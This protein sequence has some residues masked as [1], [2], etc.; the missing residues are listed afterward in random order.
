M[1]MKIRIEILSGWPVPEIPDP[2]LV[3]SGLPR[4]AQCLLI[5]FGQSLPFNAIQG[6]PERHGDSFRGL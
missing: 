1:A 6:P 3:G 5:I 4:V 2:A